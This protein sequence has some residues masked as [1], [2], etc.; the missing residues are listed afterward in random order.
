MLK[1]QYTYLKNKDVDNKF[2]YKL[3]LIIKKF[4]KVLEKDKE[5]QIEIVL[6]E[7]LTSYMF[8]CMDL[9]FE[10][11]FI[12]DNIN[13]KDDICEWFDW[14]DEESWETVKEMSYSYLHTS[15]AFNDIFNNLLRNYKFKINVNVI[16][17][18]NNADFTKII[19]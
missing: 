9:W 6:R 17:E 1:Q 5:R 15:I 4:D 18:N 3:W 14:L 7:L 10:E 13:N 12:K 11:D 19:K 2:I 16:N 8:S